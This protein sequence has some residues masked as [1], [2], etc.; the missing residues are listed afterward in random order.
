M[1]NSRCKWDNNMHNIE[2]CFNYLLV[3]ISSQR[4]LGSRSIISLLTCSIRRGSKFLNFSGSSPSGPQSISKLEQGIFF[5]DLR[6]AYYKNGDRNCLYK[7]FELIS[8]YMQLIYATKHY[9]TGDF[10]QNKKPRIVLTYVIYL[11]VLLLGM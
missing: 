6:Q 8:V 2:T 11:L 4:T 3:P 10:N 9:N 5:S 1:K 7:T